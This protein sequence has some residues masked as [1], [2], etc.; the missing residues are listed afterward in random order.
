MPS[1]LPNAVATALLALSYHVAFGQFLPEEIQGKVGY[2]RAMQAMMLLPL[3][4][5]SVATRLR[6]RE[7]IGET[8]GAMAAVSGTVLTIFMTVSYFAVGDDDLI[9]KT[10]MWQK[11]SMLYTY[12]PHFILKSVIAGE[13]FTNAREAY[14]AMTAPALTQAATPR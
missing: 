3:L 2:F 5:L 12:V 14:A 10:V 13:V 7:D 9:A 6:F 8:F 1:T 11:V 4:C